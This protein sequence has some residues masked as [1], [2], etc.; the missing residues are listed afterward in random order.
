MAGE[1]AAGTLFTQSGDHGIAY[2]R[3][4]LAGKDLQAGKAVLTL[5]TA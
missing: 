3:F 5:P 1:K 4:D 2:L